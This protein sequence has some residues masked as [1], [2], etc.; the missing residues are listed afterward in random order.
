ME[1]VARAPAR[2]APGTATCRSTSFGPGAL[3]AYFVISHLPVP[4]YNTATMQS[5]EH[6]IP[7]ELAGERV[8]RALAALQSGL[9]RSHAGRL[10]KDGLVLLDGQ[11][12]KASATVRAGQILAVTLPPAPNPI[13]QPQE[14]AL[15]VLYEDEHLLVINKQ[16][17]LVVHPAPGHADGTLVNAVLHHVPELAAMAHEGRPGI[18]HRLDKGTSGVMVVAKTYAA[19]A[20]L[21]KQ[22]AG[23][24][25]SKVYLAIVIGTPK[26]REGRIE[27][28]IG[29]HVRD[30][31]RIS[32]V[33]TH[34]RAATTLYRVE[35]TGG[36]LSVLTCTLLSGRTHQIR[37]H[38]A[39]SGWPLVGDETY[40]GIRPLARLGNADL[41]AAC[42]SL[43]RPALH[44]RRLGFAHP[45]D[46][47]PLAFEAPLPGDLRHLMQL[48]EE[49]HA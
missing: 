12:V 6:A 8:D 29:R 40:G 21:Q 31:Q 42:Q 35:Q 15:D 23:R 37:V 17:G 28:A 46:G 2:P 13:A 41:R 33:T 27:L 11:P 20:A 7:P 16:A 38:C 5:I 9:T 4:D 10:A 24:S 19:M 45:A 25:V 34:G 36:G 39:E 47:R 48:M 1:P 44:A 18:V 43:G 14:I 22:F 32:S 30:R 26:D 3:P 49:P